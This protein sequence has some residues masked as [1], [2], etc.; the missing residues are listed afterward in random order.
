MA[1]I[2]QWICRKPID[3]EHIKSILEDSAKK[4]QFTNGGPVVAQL[5]KYLHNVLHVDDSKVVILVANGS[6]ALH[7]LTSGI[8]Y[9]ERIKS[10]QWATQAFT[11]P[12]SAQSNL[13]HA[14]ILDI[15]P[16][17]GGLDLSQVDSS[18][19]QG[20]IVT[21]IFGNVVDIQKYVTWVEEAKD[22][23][24]PRFLVFDNAATAFT[25]YQGKNC[26]NYGHGCTISFHHTKPFGFGEG[27]AIIVDRKYEHAIRCLNNFGIGIRP[28]AYW[29]PEGNNNK[30]SDVSA[31]FIFSYMQRHFSTIVLRHGNIYQYF[32]TTI[33]T[34][35][36]RNFKLFPSFHDYDNPIVISCFAIVCRDSSDRFIDK[37][38]D[39]GINCRRYYHPLVSLPNA[40]WLHDHILCLPCHSDM[41]ERDVDKIIHVLRS[42][43]D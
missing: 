42:L 34:S 41:T 19:I 16:D 15:D 29:I 35:P 11:F 23:E 2:S 22:S 20:L 13:S 1:A 31:S 26:V 18:S 38:S 30:M 5:E 12:P 14:M 24:P 43:D 32:K 17:Q 7:A 4:N 40:Q 6:V 28:D 9:T 36:L 33:Q 25:F 27:G 10:L 3:F 21:N 8:L 39:Q 37:I